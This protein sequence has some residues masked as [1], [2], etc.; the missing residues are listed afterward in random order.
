MQTILGANGQIGEEL[1][2]YLHDHVTPD[3]RLV[4]R[5]PRK[6]HETD[7]LHP[8]NLLDAEATVAAVAGS[9]VAYFTVGL[10][11]NWLITDRGVGRTARRWRDRGRG[12][13]RMGVLMLPIRKTSTCPT[14][15]SLAPS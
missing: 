9:D 4:S 12:L 8:A 15:P 5:N 10:P 7:Q 6:L 13:P 11:L 3:I 14:L 2:R 1:T